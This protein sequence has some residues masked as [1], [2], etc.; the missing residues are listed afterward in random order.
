MLANEPASE[1]VSTSM[2]WHKKNIKMKRKVPSTTDSVDRLAL[3]EK[4]SVFYPPEETK[5]ELSSSK[6]SN[7]KSALKVKKQKTPEREK[8]SS[9]ESEESIIQHKK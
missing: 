8:S 5:P 3:K 1:H 6:R 9:K 4:K 7:L 2:K